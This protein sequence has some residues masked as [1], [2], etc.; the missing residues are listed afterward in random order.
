[1]LGPVAFAGA[2]TAELEAFAELKAV[3]ATIA[4]KAKTTWCGR[5]LTTSPISGFATEDAH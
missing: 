4:A 1:M 5:A 2:A 3:R